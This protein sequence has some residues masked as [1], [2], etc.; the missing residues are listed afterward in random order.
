MLFLIDFLKKGCE[1]FSLFFWFLSTLCVCVRR[2]HQIWTPC[3]PPSL[4]L[5]HIAFLKGK[6]KT[7]I[8][9]QFDH[10]SQA[11]VW[12]VKE[13][14]MAIQMS[15]FIFGFVTVHT[16][17][18]LTCRVRLIVLLLLLSTPCNSN[19]GDFF[20][21]FISFY[22]MLLYWRKVFNGIEKLPDRSGSS[23]QWPR[24]KHSF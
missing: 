9:E 10:F 21:T 24:A 22:Y 1:L 8:N 19:F 13:S 20:N 16:A 18:L 15:C 6:K 14:V 2:L 3:L 4:P 5:S 11:F 12:I 17:P 23:A 7:W